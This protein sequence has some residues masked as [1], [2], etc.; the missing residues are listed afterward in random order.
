MLVSSLELHFARDRFAALH[1]GRYSVFDDDPPA[2]ARVRCRLTAA[3]SPRDLTLSFVLYVP[4]NAPTART[5]RAAEVEVARFTQPAAQSASFRAFD[6]PFRPAPGARAR[7]TLLARP[8]RA[9][10]SDELPVAVA[11]VDVA[12]LTAAPGERLEVPLEPAPG[13][14]QPFAAPAVEFALE[15][16]NSAG[17]QLV[18]EMRV[19]VRRESGWPFALA[20]P[21]F[22]LYR[23]EPADVSWTPLYRSE[24]LTKESDRNDA[25]GAMIFSMA[26]VFLGERHA[27]VDDRPLRLE[28]FH[29]KTTDAPKLVAY[30]STSLREL[31]LAAEGAA[32]KLELNTFLSGELTG[33]LSVHA[34]RV[35]LRRHFF[36]LEADLG[37]DVPGPSVYMDVNL[38][39]ERRGAPW[40]RARPCYLVSRFNDRCKWEPI[41][42][43]SAPVRVFSK[44]N[45]SKYKIGKISEDKFLKGSLHRTIAVAFFNDGARDGA[46]PAEIGHFI[47]TLSM[48]FEASP[49]TNFVLAGPDGE[50]PCPGY[51]VFTQGGRNEEMTYLEF[52]CVL[53][54]PPPEGAI[55]PLVSTGSS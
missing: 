18:L 20:R 34:S 54:R 47:T 32:L 39:E 36:A 41:Y 40:R 4:P 53:G 1:R 5:A 30:L 28:L 21:F 31:R 55:R 44:R 52:T 26:N 13:A 50:G 12:A 48:L 19:R 29:Y 10:A 42:R 23:W 14:Q 49:G 17:V 46:D 6:H 3:P 16:V 38:L 25:K 51:V 11:A 45:Y 37:G 27:D 2:E 33:K 9:P 35:T 7:L 24:V 22:V 15:W 43:S 8:P